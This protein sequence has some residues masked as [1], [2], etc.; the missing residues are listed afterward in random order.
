MKDICD[1]S[2]TEKDPNAVETGYKHAICP[3]VKKAFLGLG[4]D[5]I[6]A[7]LALYLVS[8]VNCHTCLSF[9]LRFPTLIKSSKIG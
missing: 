1:I 8:A 9:G 3:N 4:N 2:G 6:M 5:Y 7:K